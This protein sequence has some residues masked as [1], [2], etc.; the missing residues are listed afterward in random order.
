MEQLQGISDM[1]LHYFY[2]CAEFGLVACFR[3]F[4]GPKHLVLKANPPGFDPNF[5]RE[6]FNTV[7]PG[8]QLPKHPRQQHQIRNLFHRKNPCVPK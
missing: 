6:F 5:T 4:N 2:A 3:I 1:A 7:R 8:L